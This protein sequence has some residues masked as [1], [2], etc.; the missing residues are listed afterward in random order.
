MQSLRDYRITYRHHLNCLLL[1]AVG[2]HRSV[3]NTPPPRNMHS[4]GMRPLNVGNIL[5]HIGAGSNG[6]PV[7]F[8][9]FF[10]QYIVP[11]GTKIDKSI[12]INMS[13]I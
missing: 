6:T 8:V 5:R 1:Q 3:E 12:I 2:L 4:V 13:S 9:Q 10:Y 11:N 7:G